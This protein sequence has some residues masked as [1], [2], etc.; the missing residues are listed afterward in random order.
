MK[1]KDRQWHENV[2]R[3]ARSVLY[4]A[5]GWPVTQRGA[6]AYATLAMRRLEDHPDLHQSVAAKWDECI[7]LYLQDCQGV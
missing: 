4:S 6:L 2:A 7:K 5:V 3:R 1:G